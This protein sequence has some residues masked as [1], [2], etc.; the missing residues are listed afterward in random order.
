MHVIWRS[1]V[2]SRRPE[3][4]PHINLSID[5]QDSGQGAG[6]CGNSC[7]CANQWNVVCGDATMGE[8]G[9]W[10]DKGVDRDWWP[11]MKNVTVFVERCKKTLG[12]MGTCR[13]QE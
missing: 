2:P 6:G 1:M 8:P 5:L 10:H 12:E 11:Y 7:K 9:S 13:L 3:A 4:C